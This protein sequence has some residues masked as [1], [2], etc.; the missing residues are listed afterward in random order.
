M[1]RILQ[2]GAFCLLIALLASGC[3][4]VTR[5]NNDVLEVRTQPIQAEVEIYRLDRGFTDKE[6]RRNITSDELNSVKRDNKGKSSSEQFAGPFKAQTP[7]TF[8]LARKGEYRVEIRKKG[9]EPATVSIKNKVAGGGAA[10]MA[11]NVILGGIIGAGVDAGT[12]AMLNLIPNP[13]DVQL[14]PVVNS[15]VVV[16]DAADVSIDAASSEEPDSTQ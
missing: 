8:S 4:S 3:A 2:N 7:A 14:I 9:Y 15:S 16:D 1:N 13:V 5:G 6:L 12:G 11:G 10:G